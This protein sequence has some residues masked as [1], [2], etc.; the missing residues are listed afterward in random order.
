MPNMAVAYRGPNPSLVTLTNE[1]RSHFGNP[2]RTYEFV[3]GYK[4]PANFSGHNPDSNGIVHAVDIFT[5]DHGNIPAAEGRALAERLRQ[6]GAATN[7][8][9]YLIHD[10]SPGA[11]R[12][13]IAGQFN[14]WVWQA[15][16]GADAHSDHIHVSIADG[17]WGD[18][19]AVGAAVYNNTA[20]WGISAGATAQAD[21]IIPIQE[22]DEVTPEDR[23]A[24]A[25]TVLDFQ[26]N[27]VGGGKIT[28]ANMLSEYRP[29]VTQTQGVVGKVASQVL[30][31]EVPRQGGQGGKTTLA[32]MVAWNDNH[33]I[34]ILSAVAATAAAGG[35]SVEE[36]QAAV[37]AALTEGVVQVDVKVNGATPLEKK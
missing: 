30:N 14:G 18:P 29:H 33:I 17:Y 4:S 11:P 31:T 1:L 21:N 26:V 19:C 6:I 3:T 20:R 7:R 22:D 37:K 16:G 28:L 34:Q 10:M 5:D 12:P 36:I 9:S 32:G 25:R 8:F 2:A 23:L 27:Q 24:I 15:Y 35:A 13:M